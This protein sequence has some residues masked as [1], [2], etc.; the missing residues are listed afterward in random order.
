MPSRL[1]RL[2]LEYFIR[3]QHFEHFSGLRFCT[4]INGK[5]CRMLFS[6]SFLRINQNRLSLDTIARQ[7]R[8]ILPLSRTDKSAIYPAEKG[9]CCFF[10]EQSW[11]PIKSFAVEA[12]AVM[13]N[14]PATFEQHLS[15]WYRVRCASILDLKGSTEIKKV[16]LSDGTKAE[17]L[18][19]HFHGSI[20]NGPRGRRK[21]WIKVLFSET[22]ISLEISMKLFR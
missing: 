10:Q 6:M 14:F 13:G 5:R 12:S 16:V 8:L 4:F 9:N 2:A 20:E 21:W 11:N 7:W 18:P 22:R 15:D 17:S 1:C 3:I 19:G